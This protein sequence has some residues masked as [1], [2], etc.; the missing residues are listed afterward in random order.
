MSTTYTIQD[1]T[2]ASIA[3]NIREQ[4][5]EPSTK[6]YTPAQMASRIQEFSTGPEVNL[7]CRSFN[8]VNVTTGEW[9]RPNNWPDIDALADEI[10]GDQDCV[11]LTYDLSVHPEF[12]WIGIYV[13]MSS[14]NNWYLD[15][16][17]EGEF[18]H[19]HLSANK[20]A[21]IRYDLTEEPDDNTIQVWRLTSDGHI[22]QFGFATNTAGSN[23]YQCN[24]QPCVQRAG[25]LPWCTKMGEP[26]TSPGSTQYS[27]GGATI[28]LERDAIVF[29]TK[30]II[31]TLGHFWV[32]AWNLQSIDFSKLD[33]KNWTINDL[34][35]VFA[36]CYSL[37]SLNLDSWDTSN[38]KVKNIQYAFAWCHSLKFLNLNS[39]DT[40]NWAVENI[41]STWQNCESLK[42]LLINQWN[43]ENW[44]IKSLLNVWQNCYSLKELDLNSW[45]TSNWEVASM[46]STWYNCYSLNA[47][48]I[49][50]WDTSNWE[51]TTI[52][53]TW[54]YCYSLKKLNLNSWDTSEWKIT[55]MNSTWY[56][57]YSLQE[58]N[59][60]SLDTSKWAVMGMSGTWSNC[61]SLKE[62]NLNS[63]NTSNWAVTNLSSIWQYCYNLKNLNI[64]SWDTSNWEVTNISSQFYGCANLN[65]IDIKDWDTSGWTLASSS[66]VFA[67]NYNLKE[68]YLPASFNLSSSSKITIM[69]SGAPFLTNTYG[70]T[71]YVNH[72][73][74]PFILLTKASL[75][76]I[77]SRLPTITSSKTLTLG[78][79]NILKL[80]AEEIAVATAKGWTVA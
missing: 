16:Y 8:H 77:I 67:N 79:Q 38:W 39:W 31:S 32:H 55:N 68:L 74:A 64:D 52:G 18:V 54:Q 34:S 1:T 33:T 12:H 58:L 72:S 30:T 20:N 26:G 22:S 25:T 49:N 21:Y 47:L 56:G 24:Y 10:E 36:Y 6:T 70:T 7:F 59:I 48:K 71:M 17:D 13:N 19:T 76:S 69:P 15:R 23:N 51:V 80:T 11:Y 42:C 9:E 46:G 37:R 44:A 53:S 50:N 2:L 3:N 65:K 27:K 14:G 75:N 29:G 62:L 66:S 5:K 60:S 45:D 4:Y 41:V 63:W 73:Y 35:Y 40:S 61:H 28:W 57:C 78:S 43:T